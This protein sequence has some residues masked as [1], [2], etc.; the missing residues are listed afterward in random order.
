MDVCA[1]TFTP[2]QVNEFLAQEGL[3]E[4][5]PCFFIE[6]GRRYLKSDRQ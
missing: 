6:R 3:T 5:N 2:E 1:T 4:D